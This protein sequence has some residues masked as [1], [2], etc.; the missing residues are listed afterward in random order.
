MICLNATVLLKAAESSWRVAF[1]G[2]DLMPLFYFLSFMRF[3][4]FSSHLSPQMF[5]L[6]LG[7]CCSGL[8]STAYI[9]TFPRFQ[10][11]ALSATLWQIKAAKSK[12]LPPMFTSNGQRKKKKSVGPKAGQAVSV[13]TRAVSKHFWLPCFRIRKLLSG[14][15]SQSCPHIGT[16]GVVSSISRM[17]GKFQNRS[18]F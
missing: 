15:I 11:C 6:F 18:L 2:T 1:R 10:S 12:T 17:S 5:L 14:P 4:G 3:A 16:P 13:E 7:S 8:C 9:S